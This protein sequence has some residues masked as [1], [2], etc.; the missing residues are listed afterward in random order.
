MTVSDIT[1]HFL[2]PELILSSQILQLFLLL[3]LTLQSGESA[4]QGAEQMFLCLQKYYLPRKER[5]EPAPVSMRGRS[6]ALLP[7]LSSLFDFPASAAVTCF[8]VLEFYYI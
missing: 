5:A 8:S 3:E 4:S 6:F 7:G 2:C 1:Y